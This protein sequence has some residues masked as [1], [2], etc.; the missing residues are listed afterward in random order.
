VDEARRAW[1]PL[2][3]GDLNQADTLAKAL[4]A[5]VVEMHPY[6]GSDDEHS[7]HLIIGH[8]CLRRGDVDAAAHY[9]LA[10]AGSTTLSLRC[11]RSGRTCPSPKRCCSAAGRTQ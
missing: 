2:A 3:G 6:H 5:K 1:D 7:A 10:A 4:M 9:L 11:A 8:V